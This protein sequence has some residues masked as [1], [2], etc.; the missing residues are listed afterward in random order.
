MSTTA[1]SV[2]AP[3]T[4]TGVSTYSTQFQQILTRAV[5]IASLPL[6]A[7]QNQD[8]TVLQQKSDLATLGA[9]VTSLAN[10][11]T[12]LQKA[13]S[14]GGIQASSSDSTVISATATGAQGAGSYT[15]NSITS[16]ASPASETSVN[17]YPD[18]TAAK[19]SSTGT[20]QLV[21][22]AK[23]YT[24]N[25]TSAQNNLNGLQNAINSLGVGVTASVLTTGTGANADYLSVASSTNG[26]TTLQLIDDP[27]GAKTNLL[28]AT[29]QGTDAVF[30]LNGI[31]VDNQ[32]N[33]I[34]NVV[35]GLSFTLLQKSATAQTLTLSPSQSALSTALSDFVSNYNTLSTAMATQRGTANGS[36]TGNTVVVQAESALHQ[37]AGYWSP[38]ST[39]GSVQSL[40]DLGITFD[41][42]GKATFDPTI[43]SGFNETQLNS[44]FAFVGTAT[45]GFASAGNILQQLSDPISGAIVTQEATYTRADTRLQSQ[46]LTLQTRIAALQTST[47]RQLAAMDTQVATLESQQSV[48]TASIQAVDLTLFGKNTPV[49]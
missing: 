10:T 31:T 32:S 27:T 37:I 11:F 48:L 13:V 44:A 3:I 23:T 24:I 45:K 8:A 17:G 20:V 22:G 41:T 16:L 30:Q 33:V 2:T 21:V 25:L 42:T 35:P 29:N 1:T 26:K 9:S 40:S 5:N 12:E 4:F 34:N 19:V 7:L 18:S 14:T 46:I 28:T 43:L 39:A 49:A 38:N 15:I 6:T 36:L 47:Q